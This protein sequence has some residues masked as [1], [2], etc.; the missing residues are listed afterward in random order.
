M[1]APDWP[2]LG[3]G[4][5]LRA[6]HYG[7][8]LNGPRRVDWFEAITENYI[9]SGGRPLHVLERVRADCP[10]ALHGVALSIG[11][12]DPLNAQYL[13]HLCTLV[14]SIEPALVTDHLCWT[15]VDGRSLYDLLPLP[16]TEEALHHV[17]RRVREVQDRLGR[18]ILLENPST[19]VQFRHSAF[20]EWEFLAAVAEEADCGILLDVNNVYVSAYNHGFDPLR[21][22]DGIPA[23]RVGQMHLA[24]YTDRG[25]YLF[26]THS[27]PVSEPVWRLFAHAV[28]RFG[29]VSTLVEWDA[30]IPPFDRVCAEAERARQIAEK[31]HEDSARAHATSARI[32]AV[33]GCPDRQWGSTRRVHA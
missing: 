5:G 19:Y 10:L 27:A 28:E 17:V 25:T 30:D 7:D 11:S 4:V 8:I 31:T 33:D 23:A 24:G 29:K 14:Q 1:L 6:E 22:L 13:R 2:R 20:S 3:F 9:D 12:A 26:D 32:A 16:Y 15:G 21:Y 18:R